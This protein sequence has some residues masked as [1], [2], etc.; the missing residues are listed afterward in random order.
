MLPIFTRRLRTEFPRR[1][2]VRIDEDPTRDG[3]A[4]RT[5]DAME[6]ELRRQIRARLSASRLPPADSISTSRRGTGVPCIV[7]FR[8]ID[9]THVE[10]EVHSARAS[11]YAHE[12]C[13]KVWREESLARRMPEREM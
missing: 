2:L 6:N 11:L 8:P 12:E 3:R 13:Y 7:C 9:S 5:P 1:L 10:R 4:S